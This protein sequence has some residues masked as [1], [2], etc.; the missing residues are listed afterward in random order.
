MTPDPASVAV[1]EALPLSEYEERK[2][3]DSVALLAREVPGEPLQW[4]NF[5]A[6]RLLATLD[7]ARSGPASPGG[8]DEVWAAAEAALP[9]GWAITMLWGTITEARWAAAAGPFPSKTG[10]PQTVTGGDTPA[11]ALRAFAA[12]LTEEA[13]R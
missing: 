12:R 4:T 5:A 7:A 6:R 10:D 2:F 11:A 8:L 13:T 1:E 9:E 3:R